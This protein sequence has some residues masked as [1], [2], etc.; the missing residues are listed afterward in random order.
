MLVLPLHMG[1]LAAM[2]PKIGLYLRRAADARVI[3]MRQAAYGADVPYSNIPISPDAI[4]PIQENRREHGAQRQAEEL[5]RRL[6]D[7][8]ISCDLLLPPAWAGA[9]KLIRGHK[10][11]LRPVLLQA[12]QLRGNDA[13]ALI[14][15]RMRVS[16]CGFCGMLT[17]PA[18]DGSHAVVALAGPGE[19]AR[20]RRMDLHGGDDAAALTVELLTLLSEYRD[21]SQVR[22]AYMAQA[23]GYMAR[24]TA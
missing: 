6:E 22:T 8:G 17:P 14:K 18:P 12:K 20:M 13:S 15:R 3:P 16:D 24:A 9:A 7:S 23:T 19:Y 21:V 2:E 10:G 4:V 1:L 11:V 5:L